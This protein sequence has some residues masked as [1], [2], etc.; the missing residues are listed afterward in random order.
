MHEH[1]IPMTIKVSDE[2]Q[3]TLVCALILK[4]PQ[5]SK[6]DLVDYIVK[7]IVA[8]NE[9]RNFHCL[10]FHITDTYAIVSVSTC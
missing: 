7:L 10:F 3:W 6:S 1:A 8:K 9:V 4:P 5:F 2:G